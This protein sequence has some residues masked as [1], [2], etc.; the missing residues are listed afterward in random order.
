MVAVPRP[1]T[2]ARAQ[3]E[4]AVQHAQVARCREDK[5]AAEAEMQEAMRVCAS[6]AVQ[7]QVRLPSIAGWLPAARAAEKSGARVRGS[8][9]PRRQRV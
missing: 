4:M 6:T 8:G 7:K 2:A 9:C 3:T 1:M 5:R